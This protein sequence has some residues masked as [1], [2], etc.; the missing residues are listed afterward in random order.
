MV[1]WRQSWL[2]SCPNGKRTLVAGANYLVQSEAYLPMLAML[3][4]VATPSKHDVCDSKQ[5]RFKEAMNIS[6]LKHGAELYA[7]HWTDWL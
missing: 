7:P 5:L 4:V 3:A 6:S 2:G 1:W